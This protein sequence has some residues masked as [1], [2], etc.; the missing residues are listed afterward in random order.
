MCSVE[1]CGR[2]LYAR[3]FCCIHYRRFLKHGHT[4]KIA[5][6][7]GKPA[8][9]RRDLIGQRF[10][11]LLVL[12]LSSK[13]LKNSSKLYWECQCNCGNVKP[14]SS[15]QLVRGS[16][17]SCG[18]IKREQT[19]EMNTI[20]GYSKNKY[21]TVWSNIITRC[22][23]KNSESYEEY[24]ARG[25]FMCDEWKND[26]GAFV[27][28]CET[29]EPIPKGHSI[30]RFPDL[31]GPYS[32]QNCRFASNH[33]QNRNMRSNIWVEFNGERLIFKDFIKKYGVVDYEVARSRYRDG[34]DPIKA[35][36][37]PKIRPA[38][39]KGNKYGG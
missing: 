4:T 34:W 16:T 31:N 13:K 18:C 7:A 37:T 2:G 24:G 3:G 12:R 33:Q 15:S 21:Y 26:V 29:Q 22:Y 35:A 32:P 36:M 11:R 39:I 8:R 38:R 30:D 10:G 9:N 27:K 17:Q 6:Q 25:V 14:V 5:Y 19:I 28:W 1:G 23:N 20:H